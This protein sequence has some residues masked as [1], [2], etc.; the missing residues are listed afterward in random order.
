M[1]KILFSEKNI[2][3][4]TPG[5]LQ[6][7]GHEVWVVKEDI[8]GVHEFGREEFL[9]LLKEFQPDVLVCGLK[10]QINKEVLE[11]VNKAV[12]TRTTGQD[13][14][15]LAYAQEKGIEIINLKGE[16]LTNVEAVPLL[17]LWAILELIRRRDG[18]EL[19]DKTLGVIGGD[20]R[21]AQILAGYCGKD[22]H[23]LGMN[24]LTYDIKTGGYLNNLLKNSD[25]ISLHI[26]S[27]EE[28]RNF[29]DLEKFK[30]MKDGAYF[31]NSARPW[32]MEEE[33]FKWALDNKL[34]GAWVDFE[35]PFKHEKLIITPHLGG[36]TK[37]SSSKTETIICDKIIK[38]AKRN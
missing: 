38:Y 29:I 35:L 18:Q 2:N 24:I 22:E 34:A 3:Q 8:K 9:T 31:L 17:T 30:M 4:E 32:L 26:S 23:S 10:F 25:I 37:E 36:K 7:A 19:R 13:H 14:I 27:T 33:G 15:D 1:A 12:F 11:Y 6:Q 20:G 5:L 21:V 16:E 28:N